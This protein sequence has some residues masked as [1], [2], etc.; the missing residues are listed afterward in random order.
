MKNSLVILMVGIAIAAISF[1]WGYRVA[2]HQHRHHETGHLQDAAWLERE[3]SLS[4]NT[5]R[6]LEQLALG[7]N[8]RLS[9]YCDV[10]CQA[11]AELAALL[12]TAD[13]QP[14]VEQRLLQQMADQQRRTDAAMLEHIR[15]VH[16]TLPAGKQEVYQQIVRDCFSAPCPHN[17][18]HGGMQ[19]ARP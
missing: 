13:W 17:L 6:A 18:H 8:E 19:A 2:G 10:H 5:V 14:D 4:A 3:L 7:F 9:A 1:G 16:T 11:R 15:Q 12:W